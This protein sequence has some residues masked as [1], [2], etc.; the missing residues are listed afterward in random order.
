VQKCLA[1]LGVDLE[2]LIE[3]ETIQAAS[4]FALLHQNHVQQQGP[5]FQNFLRLKFTKW[6]KELEC[7]SLAGLALNF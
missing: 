5:T 6:P 2:D 1:K 4:C 7:L 3:Y